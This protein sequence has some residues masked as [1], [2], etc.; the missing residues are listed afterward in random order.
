MLS[1]HFL[2]RV[3]QE[4]NQKF[5]MKVKLLVNMMKS[6]IERLN[7]RL[8]SKCHQKD[9][10]LEQK[11]H[12]IKYINERQLIKVTS[13]KNTSKHCQKMC[14]LIFY[15]KKSSPISSIHE[16]VVCRS[17]KIYMIQCVVE[18][19]Y[20]IQYFSVNALVNRVGWKLVSVMSAQSCM[21]FVVLQLWK[22]F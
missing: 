20:S 17:F 5:T 21:P 13:V 16:A 19:H 3:T 1:C 6:K 8:N 10:E 18:K 12:R 4:N 14:N 7:H 9:L 22:H 11:R 15:N 2:Q